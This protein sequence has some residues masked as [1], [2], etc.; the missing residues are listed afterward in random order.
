MI[1]LTSEIHIQRLFAA[2][3]SSRNGMKPF[4]ENRTS[5]LKEY[6]GSYYNGNGAP[7]EVIVNLI[8][9]TADV[10]TIGLAANNPKVN[11]TTSARELLPFANR[12]K[13]GINNQIKEMRFAQTLQSIVLDSLFGLGISKTH[14]AESDPIQLDDDIWADVGKIYVGRISLDDF[15]MDLTAK[16][17]RRCKFMS[18]EYRVSW[19][20]CKNHEAFDK[21]V[22]S[23]MSATSKQNRS[24]EQA[25]DISGGLLT[26]D[27]E[28]EPMV[29]LIDVW[30]PELKSIA[31]FPRNYPT[32]P[33]AVLPW[34]GA[35]GGC[36]D[37]LSFSDVPDNVLPSSPMSNLRALH[38]LYNGLVRKQSRQAKRQKTNPAYR[39][40]AQSDAENLKKASDGDWVKVK[41]PSGVNVIKQGGV[42]QE[43]VAFSIGIMD[44]FDRQAG[45]LSAMAGL[46]AQA[47]TVGQEEL[48]HAAVSR[49]EAK[50]Q[51]RVHSYTASVMGKIGHMMWADEFLELSGQTEAIAGSGIMVESSWT[52]EKREGDFW[53]YNF[54]IIPGSTNYESTEAKIGKIERAMEKLQQ[55]YPMIQ[56][57][58]GEIDVEALTRVYAEYLEIPEIQNIIT[59]SQ[60]S[61]GMGGGG[62]SE[63]GM[64]S[65]TTRNYVRRNVPTGGTPQARSQALQQSMYGNE[66]Q[67]QQNMLNESG[68]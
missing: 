57:A 29:D 19:E 2:I 26:D 1:D 39:P 64:P 12:F 66:S 22:L 63:Q 55:L 21:D 37:L 23:K 20:T 68:A 14:L 42:A 43:N 38:D 52:P 11:I 9:Q 59:F 25:N 50:M 8:A 34:D 67:N 15:V 40:D 27:D 36:Y 16:E 7:Y 60:P 65:N 58:G 6:V 17:V 47:G 54:D 24:D 41:D 48:I 18:D 30:L 4:R 31:T 46:G 13:V 28:Y 53:Q 51:Q 5:M 44:L 61:G 3:D 49:K 10:Y 56:A 32:K 62:G 33:L 45:N 35:E